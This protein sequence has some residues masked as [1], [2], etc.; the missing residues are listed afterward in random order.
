M[1]DSIGPPSLTQGVRRGAGVPCVNTALKLAGRVHRPQMHADSRRFFRVFPVIR[2][3]IPSAVT[4]PVVTAFLQRTKDRRFL[5]DEHSDAEQWRCTE[6]PFALRTCALEF[7][8]FHESG[9]GG[10]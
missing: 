2:G 4:S 9:L 7:W 5:S 1:F 8:I 10:R 6:P 3:Y